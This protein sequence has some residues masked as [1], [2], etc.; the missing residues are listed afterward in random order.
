MG[1]QAEGPVVFGCGILNFSRKKINV[2][3]ERPSLFPRN[4]LI[5]SIFRVSLGDYY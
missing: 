4:L 2:S 3:E 5:G 1:R